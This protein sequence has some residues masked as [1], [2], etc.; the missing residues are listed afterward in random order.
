[1]LFSLVGFLTQSLILALEE[2]KVF[3]A[4]EVSQLSL[5]D[6]GISVMENEVDAIGDDGGFLGCHRI[7]VMEL[8]INVNIKLTENTQLHVLEGTTKG[9][10]VPQFPI[11][12]IGMVT[13]RLTEGGLSLGVGQE[14]GGDSILVHDHDFVSAS[15]QT[16]DGGGVW[17]HKIK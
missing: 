11:E 2:L 12:I 8:T 10:L 15:T 14:D 5:H 4:S 6:R 13:S 17:F 16:F 7:F 9:D 1:M 3:D